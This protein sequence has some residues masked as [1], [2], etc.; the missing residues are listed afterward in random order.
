MNS[1]NPYIKVRQSLNTI[2]GFKATVRA[3]KGRKRFTIK[4]CIIDNV[5]DNIFTVLYTNKQGNLE[6]ICFSYADILTGTIKI[7]IFSDQN[8]NIS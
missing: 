7:T 2:K 6:N 4:N 8:K 3:I 1:D 5:Y